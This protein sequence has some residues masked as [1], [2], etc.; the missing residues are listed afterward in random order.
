M[1]S[2]WLRLSRLTRLSVLCRSCRRK[3]PV[4]RW[5]R[6]SSTTSANLNF[7]SRRS[8]AQ[9]LRLKRTRRSAISLSALTWQAT[10]RNKSARFSYQRRRARNQEQSSPR[11]RCSC[12]PTKRSG[13]AS[14]QLCLEW[15]ETRKGDSRS[16]N[17]MLTAASKRSLE[18]FSK[19]TTSTN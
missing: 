15:I 14:T 12:N 17:Q 18:Q 4:S 16:R 13:P 10:L 2:F 1:T 19:R 8:L 3:L 6:N 7:C 9:E 11:D 5:I